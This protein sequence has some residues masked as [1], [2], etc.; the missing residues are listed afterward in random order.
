MLKQSLAVGRQTADVTRNRTTAKVNKNWK[1]FKKKASAEQIKSHSESNTLLSKSQITHAYWVVV[2]RGWRGPQSVPVYAWYGTEE[3]SC[4][5]ITHS[6]C[7][8]GYSFPR[9]Y[10]Y[11]NNLTGNHQNESPSRPRRR[12]RDLDRPNSGPSFASLFSHGVQHH[13]YQL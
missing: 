5:Y 12:N 2:G 8:E 4:P 6:F 11:K 10:Q 1:A 13:R 7:I 9:Y 3:G